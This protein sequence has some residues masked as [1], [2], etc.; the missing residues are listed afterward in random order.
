MI[1]NALAFANGLDGY[2]SGDHGYS[3]NPVRDQGNGLTLNLQAPRI[4]YGPPLPLAIGT[5]WHP[6]G[7]QS[8]RRGGRRP[9]RT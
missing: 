1:T 7:R 5:P 9:D 2:L 8:G 4:N 3:I 6:A